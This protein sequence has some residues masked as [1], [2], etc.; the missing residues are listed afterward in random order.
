MSIAAKRRSTRSGV[1]RHS[2]NVDQLSRVSLVPL[3]IQT[4]W[5]PPR[6]KPIDIWRDLAGHRN[7]ALM[8]RLD[9]VVLDVDHQQAGLARRHGVERM[10]FAHAPRHPI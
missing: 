4:T 6:R 2:C 3:R 10:Q 8:P 9:E 7:L 1:I 5:P